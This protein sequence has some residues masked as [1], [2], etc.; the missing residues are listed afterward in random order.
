MEKVWWEAVDR[1]DQR[2]PSHHGHS[3]Y[4]IYII[5]INRKN[6]L[7][8]IS[9]KDGSFCVTFQR[10][11]PDLHIIEVFLALELGLAFTSILSIKGIFSDREW[12]RKPQKYSFIHLQNEPLKISMCCH[13]YLTRSSDNRLRY[14]V[15]PITQ[16]WGN[17]EEYGEQTLKRSFF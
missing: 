16:Y 12:S 17:F 1:Q 7:L 2:S 15:F 8:Y 13:I 11:H 10:P 6:G 14:P 4:I 3:W 9:I 5:Y